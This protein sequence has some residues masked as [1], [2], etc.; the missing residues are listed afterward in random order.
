MRRRWAGAVCLRRA[1]TRLDT[2]DQPAQDG[3]RA[4]AGGSGGAQSRFR[5]ARP[6]GQPCL[7]FLSLGGVRCRGYRLPTEA[8]WEYAARVGHGGVRY[9]DADAIGWYD[10]NSALRIHSVKRKRPNTW[11]LY[12]Q[13]AGV[14]EPGQCR[15]VDRDRCDQEWPIPA[16][17]ARRPDRPAGGEVPSHRGHHHPQQLWL[18]PP[19]ERERRQQ[20]PRV[21]QRVRQEV[22][23]CQHQRQRQEQEKRGG[24]EHGTGYPACGPG[25][26][27]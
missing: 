20:Q 4:V 25:P 21:A 26:Q 13:P 3:D 18:A 7:R 6:R 22:I 5:P 8:E 17:A 19:V 2:E 11:G 24:E 15:Q 10:E 14:L 16:G 12:R 23:A 9:G 27:A 1:K